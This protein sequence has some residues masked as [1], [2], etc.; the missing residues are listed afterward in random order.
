VAAAV[1]TVALIF[2]TV[3]VPLG[4]LSPV[5][6]G[7]GCVAILGLVAFAIARGMAGKLRME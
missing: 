7:C 1:T 2:A 4:V 6:I 3:L 5:V